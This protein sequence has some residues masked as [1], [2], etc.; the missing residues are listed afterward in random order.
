MIA[1]LGLLAIVVALEAV[2]VVVDHF[3]GP[4]P[5]PKVNH[6]VVVPQVRCI[7][8]HRSAEVAVRDVVLAVVVVAATAEINLLIL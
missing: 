7:K 2:P 4:V 8:K 3:R 1:D 5:A 6:P